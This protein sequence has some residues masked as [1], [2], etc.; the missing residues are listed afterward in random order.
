MIIRALQCR[1]TESGEARLHIAGWSGAPGEL[2]D[3]K[4]SGVYVVDDEALAAL[5]RLLPQVNDRGRKHAARPLSAVLLGQPGVP[6]VQAAFKNVR[7]LTNSVR[8]V[9]EHAL[10]DRER[11]PYVIGVPRS[12]FERTAAR[13]GASAVH[14]RASSPPDLDVLLSEPVDVPPDLEDEVVGESQEMHLVRQWIVRA[15][16]HDHPVVILGESGTGKEVVARAVHNLNPSRKPN[17]FQPVNCG[18]IPAELFESQ[19][20]G[21]VPGAFTGGLRKGSEGMWRNAERGTIF[22]DE[23]GDLAPNHQVK[24]LRVLQEN[25]V[26]P[27]GGKTEI[28]VTAR[29]IAATNRDLLS[30]VESGEFREDLYYR[31]G[32]MTITLPPLRD[33]PEDIPVLARHFWTEIAPRRPA[34]SNDVLNELR[35]YRWRGNARELRYVLVNL[36]TTFQKS[37]PG[38]SHVKA[39]VRTTSPRENGERG[40]GAES[41]IQHFEYLRHLRRA[42]G[43]IAACQRLVKS[44]DRHALEPERRTRLLAEAGGCLTELQLL[45]TRTDRFENLAIF[46]A[47]HKLAGALMAFQS[48]LARDDSGAIRYGKKDLKDHAAAAGSVVRREAERVRRLL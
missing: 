3:G 27:A 24:L 46:E 42:G 10:R 39:V 4:T 47:T 40:N 23:I 34:L 11:K 7:S 5:R 48:H 13:T 14:E 6:L 44:I 12:I 16:S 33:R 21:Y 26:L 31:L 28:E 15:A 32:S 30:M 2:A 22:L 25:K 9:L 17:H 1:L 8:R 36:H 43:A 38:V 18:A 45:G 29:V 41:A 19:V 35:Q 37:V 20:F